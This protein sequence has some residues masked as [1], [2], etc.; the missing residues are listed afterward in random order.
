MKPIMREKVVCETAG[1]P[2]V[3]KQTKVAGCS[4]GPL[5]HHELR[6]LR[7]PRCRGG[8]SG[9]SESLQQRFL[10]CLPGV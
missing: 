4:F 3:Q 10:R 5:E 2:Q 8:S 6:T 1:E 9:D 7:T